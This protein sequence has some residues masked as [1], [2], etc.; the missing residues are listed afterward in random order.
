MAAIPCDDGV[1]Q[2]IGCLERKSGYRVGQLPCGDHRRGTAL[3]D[4]D[5]RVLIAQRPAGKP[6]A[7]LW[8]FPGGKVGSYMIP[9]SVTSI[10]DSAFSHCGLTSV[11]IPDSVTSV[12][13]F[14]F[15]GSS[16]T[17]ITLGSG[18]TSIGDAA[19]SQ[20]KYWLGCPLINVTIPN[21]VTSIGDFAFAYCHSLTNVLHP[22]SLLA[23]ERNESPLE[24]LHGAP[25]R[26]RVENQLGY[27]MVKWIKSVEFVAG[28]LPERRVLIDDAGVVDEQVRGAMAGEK[29]GRPWLDLA[30]VS[31][32]HG[33]ELTFGFLENRGI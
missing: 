15:S 21:S 28:D 31:D 29:P 7:G 4:A 16:L 32:V 5:A 20:P 27:K 26:L 1:S 12:G 33:G 18:V 8:E 6:M 10:A 3:V 25:L 19:F 23:Y 22:Q 30:F 24:P 11:T 2:T 13:D 17:N 14:A 9:N